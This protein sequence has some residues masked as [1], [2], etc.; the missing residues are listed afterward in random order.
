MVAAGL[1]VLQEAAH[2]L[3]AGVVGVRAVAAGSALEAQ[4][5]RRDQ[6]SATVRLF[7]MM[8]L[9]ELMHRGIFLFDAVPRV[10]LV[11]ALRVQAR[12]NLPLV[13]VRHKY[14]T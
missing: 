7:D 11:N 9:I 8:V 3:L 14:L 1:L 5:P 6:D 2:W 12:A 4:V 13:V 10:Q